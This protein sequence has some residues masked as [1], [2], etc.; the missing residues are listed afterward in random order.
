MSEAVEQIVVSR[1]TVREMATALGQIEE[2]SDVLDAD[3][4][5]LTLDGAIRRL[6]FVNRVAKRGLG[7][8]SEGST[9]D[10]S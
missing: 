1:E 3:T 2:W 9:H 10:A 8:R 5:T 4:T 6:Q 7:A